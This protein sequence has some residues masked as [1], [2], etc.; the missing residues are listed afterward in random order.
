MSIVFIYIILSTILLWFV[1][2]SKGNWALKAAVILITLMFSL[3]IQRSLDNLSGWPTSD[4]LPEKFLVHWVLVEEP[5]DTLDEE[6]GIYLWVNDISEEDEEESWE[7]FQYNRGSEPRAYKLPYSIDRHEMI[8][9]MKERL[10]AG[11]PIIGMSEGEHDELSTPNELLN[12][13]LSKERKEEIGSIRD[14]DSSEE[15]YFYE[16]PP[17]GLDHSK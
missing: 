10:L 17:S 14:I 16:L 1:I 8:L 6:G 13:L 7:F 3:N 4:E 9:K 15:L 5:N 12:S 2:G 11:L